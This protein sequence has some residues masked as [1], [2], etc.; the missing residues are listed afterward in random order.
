MRAA[1][2][3]I[4]A[5]AF[6]ERSFYA[7][8]REDKAFAF[9]WHYHPQAELTLILEGTGQRMVGD[10]VE[11]YG[12]GDLVLLGANLPHTWRSD[13]HAQSAGVIHRALVVQFNEEP[14]IEYLQHIPELAAIHRLF[15]RARHGVAVANTSATIGLREQLQ[16]AVNQ[17]PSRQFVMLLDVLR[18]LAEFRGCRTLSS[19]GFRPNARQVD[20]TRIDQVCNYVVQHI[21]EPLRQRDLAKLVNMNAAAF[22]RFFKQM[23]GRTLMTYVNE[24]R[25]SLASRLLIE[26]D[27]SVTQIAYDVGYSSHSHFNRQFRKLKKIAPRDYRKQFRG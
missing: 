12:P 14:L 27:A 4:V 26:T 15:K 20:E 18:Q 2:E 1:Y 22:S 13:V 16:H 7:F 24:E 3:H 25:V 19:P 9:N 11:P 21:Q 10:S 8:V 6:E 17:S 23:T 5:Q